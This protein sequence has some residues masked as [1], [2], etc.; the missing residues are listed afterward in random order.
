MVILYT[1]AQ[2]ALPKFENFS[3]FNLSKQMKM[4][5]FST[6][7]ILKD[8]TLFSPFS[9]YSNNYWRYTH[10]TTYQNILLILKNKFPIEISMPPRNFDENILPK[11]G[12]MVILQLFLRKF[13]FSW[14]SKPQQV[15]EWFSCPTKFLSGPNALYKSFDNVIT[16]F[17]GE[18]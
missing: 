3:I 6:L 17:F 8:L 7:A 9:I 16:T 2:Q 13:G 10:K 14:D 4:A 15:P 11:L 18:F 1:C 5:N 12:D